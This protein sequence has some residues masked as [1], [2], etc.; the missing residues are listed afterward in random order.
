MD[1]V[2]LR[3]LAPDLA[4]PPDPDIVGAASLVDT[5]PAPGYI[6]AVVGGRRGRAS[7]RGRAAS[8]WL[9]GEGGGAPPWW[10]RGGS[11]AWLEGEGGPPRE[12]ERRWG[13]EEEVAA[14]G[15][16]SRGAEEEAAAWGGDWRG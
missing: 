5:P 8:P 11:P 2:V 4:K 1:L 9:E 10:E 12:G 6:A 16:R 7:C 14:W 15:G 3:L 13:G